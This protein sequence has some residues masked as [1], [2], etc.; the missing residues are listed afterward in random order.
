MK[1]SIAILALLLVPF[2][3]NAGEWFVGYRG[4]G[5]WGVSSIGG[6]WTLRL[7]DLADVPLSPVPLAL[8]LLAFLAVLVIGL[9]FSTSGPRRTT[10]LTS[11]RKTG[12]FL[13]GN[14]RQDWNET[15][16]GDGMLHGWSLP[17][18]PTEL[19]AGP[20]DFNGHAPRGDVPSRLQSVV[21]A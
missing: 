19:R 1:S 20:D 9:L 6:D 8:W 12:A 18:L 17:A 10:A 15:G 3:A 16:L 14:Y 21:T 13:R 11:L 4:W 2:A 7:G 5:G